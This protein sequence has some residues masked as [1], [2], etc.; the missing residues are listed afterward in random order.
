MNIIDDI[1]TNDF[2][3]MF[4]KTVPY[5][6][7]EITLIK[8]D[9]YPKIYW[10]QLPDQMN[11]AQLDF[12]HQQNDYGWSVYFGVCVRHEKKEKGRGYVGDSMFTRALWA[13]I[14][15]KT[16][17]AYERLS[18]A[19]ASFIVDSGG[20]Y[21]GYWLLNQTLVINGYDV[22][23]SVNGRFE[24]A[25]D[26]LLKRTLKGIAIAVQGDAHVCEFARI[27]RLPG[28]KNMKPG[29]NEVMCGVVQD[30]LFTHD[31]KA[32]ANQ[33]AYLVKENL[34]VDRT[35]MSVPNQDLP[36]FIKRYIAEGAKVKERNITFNKMCWAYNGLGKS[37]MDAETDLAPRARMDGLEE[38]EIQATLDSAFSTA[39]PPLISADNT[40]TAA[41]D[42]RL[43]RK[44]QS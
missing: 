2:L 7:L 3:N 11:D 23:E 16:P 15:E 21:H 13:D 18:A 34:R 26:A 6:W 9:S 12:L 29:R 24:A 10:M 35:V 30:R 25:D 5:G 37:R 19:K 28:F 31:F 27:M 32:L 22:P 36:A 44:V 4:Y 42:K 14:D 1:T 40:W 43:R 39:A 20:G 8:P 38:H 41:R 33:Y 17:E